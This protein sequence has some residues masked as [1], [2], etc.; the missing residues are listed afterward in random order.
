MDNIINIFNDNIALSDTLKKLQIL[1]LYM[2]SIEE[3]PLD[4]SDMIELKELNLN[5]NPIKVRL[6]TDPRIVI[7]MYNH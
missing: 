6:N 3:I 4:I 7:K 1:T 2:N 5:Y